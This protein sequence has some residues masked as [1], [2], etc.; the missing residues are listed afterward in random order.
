MEGDVVRRVT[1]SATG[2]GIDET[3]ASVKNLGDT[4]SDV[5]SKADGGISFTAVAASI[6][7]VGAAAVAA[8]AAMKGF[9]NLVGEQA[10][11]LADIGEAA[12]RASMSTAEYQK[13]LY[14]AMS[15]GVKEK[16]FTSG[17]EA[18]QQAI[19][20]ASQ[21]STE[22]G[23]LLKAN[24]MAIRDS[25]TGEVK[26]ANVVLG[27][28]MKLMQGAAPDI[29][30]RL[31]SIMGVSKDWIPFLRQ[32]SD[33][34]EAQKQKAATLGIIIDDST[35]NKAK[36]FEKEWHSAVAGWDLQ[37]KASI[38]SVM[39]L[40][41]QLAKIATDI[42]DGIGS[43]TTDVSRLFTPMDQ[44]N[45]RQLDAQINSIYK[46]KEMLEAGQGGV[47]TSILARM[48]Q[49][50]TDVTIPEL[51]KLLDKLSE[52]YDKQTKRVDVFTPKESTTK[53]PGNDDGANALSR[54]IDQME[55]RVAVTKA[56][57]EAVGLGAAA[58]AGLRAEMELYAAAE[59]W[60]NRPGEVRREVFTIFASRLKT[61]PTL[62]KLKKLPARF[63]AGNNCYLFRQKI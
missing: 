4:F 23:R 33:E 57:A 60:R 7:G 19:A 21:G 28:L 61:Q 62:L 1:I 50:P 31:A 52:M 16:D 5:K 41:I 13:T 32:A 55:R 11:S 15:A 9:I 43:L 14:A 34:F 37:F 58:H 30:T 18:I 36:E 51:N 38:S 3:A 45:T 20:K 35:I 29:Q 49:L 6:A 46:L 26:S 47:S 42:I 39:P 27:D 63:H 44:M 2:Q 54:T 48:L 40:L 53:L 22:F 8:M 24:G 10:K 59:R 25:V 17:F 12:E 56:D